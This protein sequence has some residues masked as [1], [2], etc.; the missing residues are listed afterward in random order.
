MK[1]DPKTTIGNQL[2]SVPNT[3]EGQKFL[4]D[5]QKYLNKKRYSIRSKGR[6]SRVEYQKTAGR[7]NAQCGLPVGLAE[8][9][10]VYLDTK[11]IVKKKVK[12]EEKY[13]IKQHYLTGWDFWTSLGEIIRYT[14]PEVINEVNQAVK[15]NPSLRDK[16]QIV[17]IK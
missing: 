5:V 14:Q 12:L 11:P 1:F 9:L 10:A 6:G 7:Y 2:F 4:A 13:A 17:E 16:L 8:Y 15:L 3:P